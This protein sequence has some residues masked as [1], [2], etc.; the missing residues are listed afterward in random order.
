M[1]VVSAGEDL[2]LPAAPLGAAD[3]NIGSVHTVVEPPFDE[4]LLELV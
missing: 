1:E 4:L 2:L 3:G